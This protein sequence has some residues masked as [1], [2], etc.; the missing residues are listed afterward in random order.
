VDSDVLTF[1]TF[2]WR[3]TPGYRSRFS[4]HHVN[5][6]ASMIARNY[7]RP[8]RFVV[9]TDDSS[10]IVDDGKVE[11]FE[12][13]HDH[14]M[15][16]NPSGRGNPSCY[17]RLRLFAPDPG[18]FLGRRF[19]CLDLDCVITGDL[20]PLFD[21]PDDF[22]IWKSN[23]SSNPYNGSMFMLRAGMRPQI[24][25]D[26]DPGLSPVQTRR[27]GLFGS[28]QAWLAYKLGPNE[29]TWSS[30]DGVYSYR[31]DIG[32]NALPADARIVF[33]HGNIDPWHAEAQRRPWVREHWK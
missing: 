16:R 29:A 15:V 25:M 22:V 28:D 14:S 4:G 1:L 12:L 32:G 6:L 19:V 3:P 26:F 10:D 13:W 21:R 18:A 2:K 33:F 7:A 23:T 5:V 27:A 31:A 30:K 17:R 11:A 9:I 20:V 8:Y 24:W